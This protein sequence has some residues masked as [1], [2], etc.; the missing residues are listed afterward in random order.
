MENFINIPLDKEKISKYTC[1][2]ETFQFQSL[3]LYLDNLR[4]FARYIK[5]IFHFLILLTV[6][7]RSMF[8]IY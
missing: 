5:S 7:Y 4:I 8:V 6:S 3:L 2:I 1:P